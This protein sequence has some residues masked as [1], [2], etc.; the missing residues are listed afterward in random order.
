MTD[1]NGTKEFSVNIV[2]DVRGHNLTIWLA[3][4]RRNRLV[5]WV[6]LDLGLIASWDSASLS[7]RQL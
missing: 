3:Q 7:T 6:L 5:I 2:L 1:L 4:Y